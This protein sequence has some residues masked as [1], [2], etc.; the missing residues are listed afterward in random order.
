MKIDHSTSSMIES[1]LLRFYDTFSAFLT[2]VQDQIRSNAEQKF[3]NAEDD[4]FRI[5]NLNDL[6]GPLIFCFYLMLFAW[7][8]LLLEVIIYKLK[9]RR[10]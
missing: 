10:N 6:R 3:S 4:D 1:G 7:F 2:D 5:V 8:I 9:S